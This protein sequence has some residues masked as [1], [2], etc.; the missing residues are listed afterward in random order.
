MIGWSRRRFHADVVRRLVDSALKI[1]RQPYGLIMSVFPNLV[2]D[3][4]EVDTRNY[5][6]FI[7]PYDSYNGV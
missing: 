6:F 1:V 2:Y 3:G 7:H 4:K 5:L